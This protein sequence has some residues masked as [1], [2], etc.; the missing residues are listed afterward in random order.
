MIMVVL[1]IERQIGVE[2]IIKFFADEIKCN[3]QDKILGKLLFLQ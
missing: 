2:N 3:E 1:T